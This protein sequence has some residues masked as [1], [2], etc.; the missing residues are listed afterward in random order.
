MATLSGLALL[1][2]AA[3]VSAQQ[4]STAPS[5]SRPP[6][7]STASASS[8]YVAEFSAVIRSRLFYPKAARPRG[9]S[10]VVGVSFSIGPSGAVS[11]FAITRSSGNKDL[12]A[13][14]RSLVQGARFPRPR[15]D[16]PTSQPVSTMSRQGSALRSLV[17][18]PF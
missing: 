7:V 4:A 13:A 16:R 1:I 5:A 15:A 8:V 18:G 6:S 3:P 2:T 12:D 10:G 17:G 11:S 14:A 9:V